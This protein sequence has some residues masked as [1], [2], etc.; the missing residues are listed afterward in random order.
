MA[1]GWYVEPVEIPRSL[2]SLKRPALRLFFTG[3]AVSL[4]GSWMQPVAQQWL[5]W[6]LTGSMQMLGWLT[7]C[8]QLP[9]LLL[10]VWA[11]S[12]I[13]RVPRKTVVVAALT[14]AG[15]QA[16]TLALLTLTGA[17]KPLHVLVLGLM[18]G[19]TYP[20]EIPARQ[21]MLAELAGDD[22]PNMVALNSMLV[23]VMRIFGP[24][25]GGLVTARWGAGWCFGINA[26]SFAAVIGAVVALP[27][28]KDAPRA[29]A[30]PVPIFA[31]VRWA[32]HEPTMRSLFV[33]LFGLS[34]F[35]L[36]W[37][38]LLPA[39]V[40]TVL[41]GG[42]DTL[43]RLLAAAGAGALV[44]AVLLVL[45]EAGLAWRIG[46]GGLVMAAG[47]L[48][49]S[50][51]QHPVF[52]GAA[53]F[54]VGLGQVTQSTGVLSELQIRSPPH[55]RGRL[56]GLFTM[57]FVGTVPLG[58]MLASWVAARFGAPL[59]LRSIAT[60]VALSAAFYLAQWARAFLNGSPPRG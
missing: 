6:R 28:A 46:I 56:L 59:A 54:F 24:S 21:T 27:T 60:V 16:S 34:A 10:G 8:L 15:L 22:L 13:D 2:R 1:R 9:S 38:T 29:S 57:I 12:V 26:V 44:S 55:L 20:F 43:G 3:Q 4:L 47:L 31:A 11:G 25:L 23:M 33:L 58:G 52:A 39:W 17:V 49:L 42:A 41:L 51:S 7:F 48:A 53:L 14:L 19:L 32:W 40:S 18:L 50:W 37:G 35:G 45:A 30:E 36:A 5:V